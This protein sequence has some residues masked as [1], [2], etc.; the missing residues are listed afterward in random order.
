MRIVETQL[1]TSLDQ[2]CRYG[3]ICHIGRDQSRAQHD[4]A[5]FH[6]KSIVL[7]PRPTG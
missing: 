7:G 3:A 6:E 2:S 5:D 4:A 1:N